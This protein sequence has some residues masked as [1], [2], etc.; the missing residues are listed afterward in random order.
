MTRPLRPLSHFSWIACA[1]GL[2]LTCRAQVVAPLARQDQ[3][4]P[5]ATGDN[6]TAALAAQPRE[7][8]GFRFGR[9][10]T[11]L[12]CPLTLPKTRLDFAETH[13]VSLLFF[14]CIFSVSW[15]IK[16]VRL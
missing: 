16:K 6:T 10:L 14:L 12:W 2:S 7:Y 8:D 13:F 1:D 3:H 15:T 5:F 9:G 11:L 4:D